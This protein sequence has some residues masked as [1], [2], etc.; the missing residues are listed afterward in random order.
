MP[1]EATHLRFALGV[2][3]RYQI[4]DLRQYLTG[5]TYP[6]SRYITGIK[7]DLTHGAQFLAPEFATNDFR[8]GWQTHELC[9]TAYIEIKQ[10]LFPG[11]FTADENAYHEAEWVASTAIKI[12]E[13][14]E[15]MQA[16]D[17]QRCLDFSTYDCGPNNEAMAILNKYNQAICRLYKGKAITTVED[18]IDLW[19]SLSPRA[20]LCDKI[21]DKAYGFLASP[22]ILA[23]IRAIYQQI[24][25]YGV[26]WFNQVDLD[27][28]G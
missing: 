1:L 12:I 13:D 19:L 18:N 22:E 8:A 20:R 17:I 6:D 7:R 26:N 2:K 9:D 27:R 21:R 24:N 28:A 4:K 11:W 14:M 15:D 5:A 23:N 10:K 25:E 3:D 16:F